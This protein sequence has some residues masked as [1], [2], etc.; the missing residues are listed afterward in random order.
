MSR[1]QFS[2]LTAV[3]CCLSL[4]AAQ[5]ALAQIKPELP[6]LPA[7]TP[8][9]D[10]RQL[11]A[12]VPVVPQVKKIRAYD[13]KVSTNGADDSAL[14]VNRT[15]NVEFVLSGFPGGFVKLEID[16]SRY[17]QGSVVQSG[18]TGT[19]E[20]AGAEIKR[21]LEFIFK[22]VAVP[23]DGVVHLHMLA[24]TTSNGI[25]Q[26][27][28]FSKHYVILTHMRRMLWTDT[29]SRA[30]S[31]HFQLLSSGPG[32]TCEG[33]SWTPAGTHPVGMATRGDKVLFRVRSGPLGTSCTWKSTEQPS[34]IPHPWRIVAYNW[35]L[36]NSDQCKQTKVE[37]SRPQAPS[38][39]LR[40]NWISVGDGRQVVADLRLPDNALPV[41][42]VGLRCSMT[43]VNDH[44]AETVWES[45]EM[46]GPV[47]QTFS[48][49]H[50][51]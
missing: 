48:N 23:A 25:T 1:N 49:F 38:G 6:R 34:G 30:A 19:T 14:Y 15:F 4:A 51:Y 45:I 12:K 43:L 21:N 22:D 33:E 32:S 44:F 3:L 28:P 9:F 10:T 37:T 46:E 18:T 50:W 8:G 35:S 13:R 26:V 29:A 2:M 39:S 7:G 42:L 40:T 20:A 31:S 36:R 47:D 11:Q 27:L 41:M 24:T 5:S 16:R 17:P